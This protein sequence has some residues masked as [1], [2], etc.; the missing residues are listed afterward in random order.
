MQWSNVG[1]SDETS[2]VSSGQ[3]VAPLYNLESRSKLGDRTSSTL[4]SMMATC[5]SISCVKFPTS[6][7]SH[8]GARRSA[9]GR[10][11][12]ESTHTL[13]AGGRGCEA[14]ELVAPTDN[15]QSA[16]IWTR[17]TKGRKGADEGGSEPNKDGSLTLQT[18][19]PLDGETH[20]MRQSVSLQSE[21]SEEHEAADKSCTDRLRHRSKIRPLYPDA[22]PT[23][24]PDLAI[25]FIHS[26]VAL[27]KDPP[28]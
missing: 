6:G 18:R 7:C 13:G 3:R 23:R 11:V 17:P 25:T 19:I 2:S 26:F 22:G 9:Y 27:A 21:V 1:P 12:P 10:P 20:R 4:L 15:A 14:G 24:E 5:G 28:A 16:S 8:D